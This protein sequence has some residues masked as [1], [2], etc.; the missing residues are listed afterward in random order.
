MKVLR[1]NEIF[2]S[3]Q[4]EGSRMGIP[5]IFI[6]LAGCNVNC[7]WCDTDHSLQGEML[8]EHVLMEVNGLSRGRCNS[9]VITGGEPTIQEELPRLVRLLKSEH[10]HI[11]IETNGTGKVPT[12]VDFIAMSPKT[13]TVT[14]ETRQCNDLKIVLDGAT[15]PDAYRFIGADCRYIMPCSGDTQPALDYV[16][17]NKGWRLGVQAHKAWGIK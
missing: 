10:Y 1:V 16:M 6:R 9:V 4:G 13:G 11:S 14:I 15:D 17:N 12:G 2:K 3:V 8:P 7:R 5:S